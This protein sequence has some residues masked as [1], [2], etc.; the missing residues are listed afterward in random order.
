MKRREAK[1]G[2]RCSLKCTVEEHPS[3]SWSIIWFYNQFQP[4]SHSGDPSL[5]LRSI[6]GICGGWNG[7]SVGFLSANHQSANVPDSS[8]T[9]PAQ[10][11]TRHV[12]T[13]S[14]KTITTVTCFSNLCRRSQIKKCILK[15]LQVCLVRV[16]V[17][18][19]ES[20]SIEVIHQ[21]WYKLMWHWRYIITDHST[22]ISF[23][24][25]P[26]VLQCE[27]LRWERHER[28]FM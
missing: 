23:N 13:A 2:P 10:L 4:A 7:S 12:D 25:L 17:C 16:F 14:L 18:D 6:Y 27:L 15:V 3:T 26:S 11:P 1:Q 8:V 20:L 9:I 22:F 5:S 24:F 21:Y 28:H 19:V